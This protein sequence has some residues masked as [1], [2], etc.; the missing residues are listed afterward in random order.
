MGIKKLKKENDFLNMTLIDMLG[1][2]DTSKTKK[3]TQLLVKLLNKKIEE[4]NQLDECLLSR[5]HNEVQNNPID[6][7]LPHS[8]WT[9]SVTRNF[10]CDYIYTPSRLV[11]SVRK[12]ANS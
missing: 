9:N 4:S 3:Y 12:P 7:V 6:R 10:I 11:Q 2:F 5:P 8:C 1:K